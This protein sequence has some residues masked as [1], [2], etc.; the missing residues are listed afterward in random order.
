MARPRV[1]GGILL[2]VLPLALALV[3]LA[4]PAI[5]FAQ[6]PPS[7][8]RSRFPPLL[9]CAPAPAPA[10]LETDGAFRAN[11]LAL[12]RAIPSAAAAAP[13]GFIA[14]ARSGGAAGRGRAFARALC[15]GAN[16]GTGGARGR[17][18]MRPAR[19]DIRAAAGL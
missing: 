1:S 16:P 11:V 12:V 14:A 10:P 6:E 13:T 7:S 15:F 8:T 18:R 17:L 9:D 3:L 2:S 19:S 5:A 4:E